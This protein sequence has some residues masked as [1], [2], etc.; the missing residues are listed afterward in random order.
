MEGRQKSEGEIVAK[1]GTNGGRRKEVGG[2]VA[3]EKLVETANSELRRV[4]KKS[5]PS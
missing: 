3:R 5:T 2:R 4:P 1:R